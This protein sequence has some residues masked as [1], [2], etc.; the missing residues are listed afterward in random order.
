MNYWA[1][2]PDNELGPRGRRAHCG[3]ITEICERPRI[4]VRGSV[5]CEGA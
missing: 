2:A 1:P 3:E 5:S 4:R